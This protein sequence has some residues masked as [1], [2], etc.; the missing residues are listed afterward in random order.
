[1][2]L[3]VDS[4][5]ATWIA[6]LGIV[7]MT[8][9]TGG[10][11]ICAVRGMSTLGSLFWGYL[12]PFLL[13]AILVVLGSMWR[14]V[15]WT[16]AHFGRARCPAPVWA[17]LDTADSGVFRRW[18]SPTSVR[19]AVVQVCADATLVIPGSAAPDR[20]CAD[21]ALHIYVGDL[22]HLQPASLRGH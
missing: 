22:D 13:V 19:R 1:M 17:C 18:M 15:T 7:N 10:R 3:L 2:L 12:A 4:F 14:G 20:R 16:R 5:S 6:I 8:V 11:P 9:P 21:R